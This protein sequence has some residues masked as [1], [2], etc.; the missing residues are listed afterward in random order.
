MPTPASAIEGEAAAKAAYLV[1]HAS[2]LAASEYLDSV[3]QRREDREERFE[4]AVLAALAN[5][6][7][8]PEPP[9]SAEIE[10]KWITEQRLAR[11]AGFSKLEELAREWVAAASRSKQARA[12]FRAAEL[13]LIVAGY[14]ADIDALREAEAAS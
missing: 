14:Q 6:E 8:P 1:L 3:E 7:V 9:G 12:R 11:A 4:R 5:G 13:R 10:S 2:E